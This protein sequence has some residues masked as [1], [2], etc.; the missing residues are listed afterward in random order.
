[1]GRKKTLEE[2][3][4]IVDWYQSGMSTVEIREKYRVTD[5]VVKRY[6][7][8][9]GLPMR[10]RGRKG[11]Q[12]Y[13]WRGGS[14]VDRDGY[15]LVYAPTHPY[16]NHQNKVRRHRL[17]M[18][19]RMGRYLRTEEVVDHVNGVKGDDRL[20]NLRLYPNNAAHLRATLKGRRPQWSEAGY[21]RILALSGVFQLRRR[22]G[23][24]IL[25]AVQLRRTGAHR[26]RPDTCPLYDMRQADLRER[27]RARHLAWQRRERAGRVSGVV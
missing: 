17:M 13:F 23:R 9:R 25:G 7:A 8:E 16:R 5:K 11:E 21:Q 24:S 10:G 27:R 3:D 18:E 2:I 12:N 20:E 26:C 1:M 15:V 14:L 6:M 22:F 19:Q 4:R